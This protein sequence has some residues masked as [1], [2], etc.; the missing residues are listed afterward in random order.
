[1]AILQRLFGIDASLQRGIELPTKVEKLPVSKRST[2][3][4]VRR[5]SFHRR[6]LVTCALIA[7]LLCG[8]ALL[9]GAS[10]HARAMAEHYA[11]G[12]VYILN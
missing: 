3:E 10:L 8:L 12:H 2:E 9:P 1:M 6:S 5:H 4:V 7:L 11:D